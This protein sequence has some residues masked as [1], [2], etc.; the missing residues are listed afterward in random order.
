MSALGIGGGI[1]NQGCL[2]LSAIML[3]FDHGLLIHNDLEI[4]DMDP[5]TTL[6]L[7]L[8]DVFHNADYDS[9]KHHLVNLQN[10]LNKGGFNPEFT[11]ARCE[12]MLD[13]ISELLD[14]V[15]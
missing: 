2:Q 12:L 6:D 7:M 5:N 11:Q 9:A 4:H 3:Q 1:G 14:Q 15:A 8:E 10:W 13:C